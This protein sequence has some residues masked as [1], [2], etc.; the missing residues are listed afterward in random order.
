MV[1]FLLH[2][3]RTV[4]PTADFR[5]LPVGQAARGRVDEGVHDLWGEALQAGDGIY[6]LAP[7]G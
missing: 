1:W 2:G 3:A 4:T 5:T 7:Q 6:S